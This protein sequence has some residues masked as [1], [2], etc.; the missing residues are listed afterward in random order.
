M[1]L[2]RSFFYS[3]AIYLVLFSIA[4]H[5]KPAPDFYLLDINS[6][7]MRTLNSYK[8]KVVYLDFWASWCK[9][10]RAS[11]PWMNEMQN[12]YGAQ[13]FAVV[14]INLDSDISAISGFTEK[15]PANFTILFNA[16]ENTPQGYELLGMPSSYLLDRKG[17]IRH[18]HTG[19]FEKYTPQYEKEIQLLLKE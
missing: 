18:T 17:K 3:V 16:D 15:Y 19:F 4:T 7:Q 14:T 8:G 9:P 1:T 2:S 13:D 12:K 5:A 10:C 11:F 6:K